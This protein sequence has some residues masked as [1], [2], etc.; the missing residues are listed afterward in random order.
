M[1]NGPT[2]RSITSSVSYCYNRNLK[3]YENKKW[4]IRH[5]SDKDY[6]VIDKLTQVR[7]YVAGYR[8]IG[9]WET[10][11]TSWTVY[12]KEREQ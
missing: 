1:F 10:D 9:A 6:E 7:Y 3:E 12:K 8:E 4:K 11:S 5:L 2:K